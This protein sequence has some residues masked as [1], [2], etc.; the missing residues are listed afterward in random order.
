RTQR[1][2]KRTIPNIFASFASFAVLLDR[3]SS[4]LS[5]FLTLG[6]SWYNGAHRTFRKSARC[7]Q[8]REPLTVSQHSSFTFHII[9][10][11]HVS[12]SRA[13]RPPTD[14]VAAGERAANRALPAP[15]RPI[16]GDKRLSL[17]VVG[18]ARRCSG[19]CRRHLRRRTAA[20]RP[21]TPTRRCPWLDQRTCRG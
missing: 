6:V 12:I 11:Q 20:V 10:Y 17:L 5:A 9:T 8:P 7:C 15:R 16:A 21:H 13:D 3:R 18:L 1:L 4:G 19:D 2:E 14:R